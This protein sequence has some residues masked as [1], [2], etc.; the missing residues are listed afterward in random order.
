MVHSRSSLR[1]IP[2]TFD[3]AFSVTRTTRALDQ[4]RLRW[5]AACLRRPAAGGLP[6]SRAHIAWR[7]IVGKPEQV[8]LAP[9]SPSNSALEPQVQHVVEIDIRQQRRENR[10]LWGTN[11]SR[12]HQSVFH[13]A[14]FEHPG[15][16]AKDT[17]VSYP[18]L[19][20]LEQPLVI[21]AVEEAAYVGSTTKLTR[22][23]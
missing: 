14:G 16:Q 5:F 10:T 21:N 9:T 3:R 19:Q 13:D 1:L 11:F 2:D 4:C 23:C 17:V 18:L 7:T 12:V 22:F 6:P 15:N 8:S 20:K